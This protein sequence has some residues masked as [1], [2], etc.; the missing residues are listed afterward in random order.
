MEALRGQFLP[1]VLNRIDEV[2]MFHTLDRKE[3]AKIVDIQLRRLSQQLQELGIRLELTEAAREQLAQEG[4]DPVYGAR[5]LKRVIQQR[6]QNH[7]ASEML[8]GKYAGHQTVVVDYRNGQFAFDGAA[9][10]PS[11]TSEPHTG[12]RR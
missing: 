9:T 1:E 7:L 5:P 11:L 3:I 12:S 4:Y 2:I 6:L 10:P 8:E